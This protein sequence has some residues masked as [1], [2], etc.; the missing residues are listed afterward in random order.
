VQGIKASKDWQ[1][2]AEHKVW[3]ALETLS[4]GE[5]SAVTALQQLST[6]VQQ[7][8][9]ISNDSAAQYWNE[10]ERLHDLVEQHQKS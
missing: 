1:K 2:V 5:Q 7:S 3:L 4:H 10:L 6:E 8:G 9:R